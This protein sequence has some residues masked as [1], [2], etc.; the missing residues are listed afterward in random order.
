MLPDTVVAYA[1]STIAFPLFCEYVVG[2]RYSRRD[3]KG[4]MHRRE[5]LVATLRREAGSASQHREADDHRKEV[6]PQLDRQR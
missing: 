5:E 4:L 6:A 2:S 1:D 3:R